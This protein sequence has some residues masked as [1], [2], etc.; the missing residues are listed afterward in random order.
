MKIGR[1]NKQLTVQQRGREVDTWGDARGTDTWT[2]VQTVWAS[3]APLRGKERLQAQQLVAET[4]HK[5]FFRYTAALAGITA[6]WRLKRTIPSVK[7]YKIIS[8][9]NVNERD[10]EFEVLAA[11]EL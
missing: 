9:F 7:Y 2:E 10:Q 3:I 6:A 11:E 8:V 5:I 4:S 1:K